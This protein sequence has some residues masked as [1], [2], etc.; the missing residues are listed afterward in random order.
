[1]S[2]NLRVLGIAAFM[3]ISASAFL[4]GQ[5]SALSMAECSVKFKA[6]KAADPNTPA[7][8]D[9]RKA[10]CGTDAAATAAPATT[11]VV[12]KTKAKPATAAVATPTPSGSFMA[13]CSANWK[14][15]GAAGTRPA[16][17]KWK[18]YISA[19][20]PAPAAAAASTATD[21]P[22]MS[23][24]QCSAAWKAAKAANTVP[25]GM[26][27]NN[28]RSA[29]CTVTAAATAPAATTAKPSKTVSLSPPEPTAV[30]NSPIPTV[31]KN[32]KALSPGQI[33]AIKRIKQCG[34]MWQQA[35]ASNK[36]PATILALDTKS[37]WP[38]YW[39]MCNKQLKA[40]GM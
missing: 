36:L 11:P 19:K 22:K 33:A 15:M 18:D 8:N 2:N 34:A 13:D 28:F 16:G 38:Q 3:A 39:S 40:K 31:D 37:R 17:M 32:G 21:A 10:Q 6:A 24:A 9:F 20:C 27:W 5:A 1:M 30:D 26:T 23:M 4:P 14:A 25:A 35:K 29:G 12:A 7:W